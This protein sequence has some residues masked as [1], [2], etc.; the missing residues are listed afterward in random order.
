MRFLMSLAL[1]MG[2]TLSELRGSMPASEVMLWAEY[3]RI[4]P[5]GDE[6]GDIQTA[7]LVS[8]IYGSQGAKVAIDEATLQWSG[9]ESEGKAPADPF[10]GLEAALM[11]A[12]E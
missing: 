2:K 11:A 5:I 9:A 7:Q 1:R 10:A 8:A 4:S 12:A 3:D 6:R